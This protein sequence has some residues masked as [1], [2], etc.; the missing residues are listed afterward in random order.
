MPIIIHFKIQSE[1]PAS[2]D[3][4]FKP[5]DSK[6]HPKQTRFLTIQGVNWLK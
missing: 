5:S 2:E 6:Y 1:K 3:F 4:D